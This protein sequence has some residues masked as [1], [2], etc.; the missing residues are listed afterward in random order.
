MAT[1]MS[2]DNESNDDIRV[3]GVGN[4]GSGHFVMAVT[5]FEV[6]RENGTVISPPSI[7]EVMIE[8]QAPVKAKKAKGKNVM[9]DDSSSKQQV[10]EKKLAGS[11]TLLGYILKAAKVKDEKSVAGAGERKLTEDSGRPDK[12]KVSR[13]EDQSLDQSTDSSKKRKRSKDMGSSEVHNISDDKQRS[14]NIIDVFQVFLV[15]TP[16]SQLEKWGPR[17]AHVMLQIKGMRSA[18][19]GRY[20]ELQHKRGI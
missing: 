5:S 8:G 7:S 19:L 16:E 17:F 13:N 18:F 1:A 15:S 3:A 2:V 12:S 6:G 20:L 9:I 11:R 4:V 14:K 10:P